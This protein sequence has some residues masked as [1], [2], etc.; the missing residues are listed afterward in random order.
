MVSKWFNET[1]INNCLK[2][3]NE[4][5]LLTNVPYITGLIIITLLSSIFFLSLLRGK[6]TTAEK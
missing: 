1:K 5:D 2:K 3:G 4:I 6:C